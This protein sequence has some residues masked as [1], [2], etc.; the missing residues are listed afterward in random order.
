MKELRVFPGTFSPVTFGHMEIA[1]HS[2][3]V[4]CSKNA[5]KDPMFSMQESKGM[6]T[7]LGHCVMTI[8]E[9]GPYFEKLKKESPNIELVMVRGI[10][11]DKDADYEL[12]VMKMNHR[13]Y[14]I[15]RFE[16]FWTDNEESGT[17]AR[18]AALNLDFIRMK[19]IMPSVSINYCLEKVFGGPVIVL[20]GPPGAGKTTFLKNSGMPYVIAPTGKELGIENLNS[21]EDITQEIKDKWFSMIT[22]KIRNA[23]RGRGLLIEIPY[24]IIYR[25]DR[26][27]GNKIMYFSASKEEL[28][29]RNNERGT[30]QFI[31]FIDNFS[32]DDPCLGTFE[33]VYGF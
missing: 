9:F 6:W 5:Y 11:N 17:S 23:E 10:R 16:Y 25:L 2:D 13:D 29:K 19:K 18:E 7:K 22:E 24:Y 3:L 12:E 4:I 8:D 28:I 14:N 15:N 32:D 33:L 20:C 27:F 21:E 30:P 26:Y 31:K 1:K